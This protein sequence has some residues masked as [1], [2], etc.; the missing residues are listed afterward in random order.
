[1]RR[2]SWNTLG[3]NRIGQWLAIAEWGMMTASAC[4]SATCVRH[5][6]MHTAAECRL[7]KR[8]LLRLCAPRVLPNLL[9]LELISQ[10][11]L[12][13]KMSIRC[14]TQQQAQLVALEATTLRHEAQF[15]S[16]N[17]RLEYDIMGCLRT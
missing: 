10:L 4:F 16:T 13:N 6:C 9:S 17:V 7:L 2:Q 15:E 3:V 11:M 8:T 12:R 14:A 1:M 5:G